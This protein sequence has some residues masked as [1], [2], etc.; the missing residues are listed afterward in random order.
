M[1][2]HDKYSKYDRR[3]N[4]DKSS[5]DRRRARSSSRSSSPPAPRDERELP[6]AFGRIGEV[7]ESDLDVLQR[8]SKSFANA[9]L[10]KLHNVING[11]L[12]IKIWTRNFQAVRGICTGYLS[13]FDKHWNVVMRDVDEA[14]LKPK[15]NKTPF[16]DDVEEGENLPELPPKTPRQ[17]KEKKDEPE[18]PEQS[19]GADKKKKKKS[20]KKS[21]T[22]PESRHVP[23]MFVRGDNIVMLTIMDEEPAKAGESTK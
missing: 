6:T 9:P 18:K 11:A 17:R 3:D 14:Y 16:L 19:E 23:Q 4:R 13:A 2:R 20:R 7:E 1:S 15:K 10:A 8:M 21:K 12:K 22:T 5:S